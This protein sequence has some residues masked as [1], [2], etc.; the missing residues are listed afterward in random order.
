VLEG[1]LS[2]CCAI[3]TCPSFSRGCSLSVREE[4][5]GDIELRTVPWLLD[6]RSRRSPMIP[7]TFGLFP[8]PILVLSISPSSTWN[9]FMPLTAAFCAARRCGQ[10]TTIVL[11]RSLAEYQVLLKQ[12]KVQIL[13]PAYYDPARNQILCAYDMPHIQDRLRTVHNEHKAKLEQLR[14][15]KQTL[16]KLSRERSRQANSSRSS[17][18]AGGSR[19]LTSRTARTP[20]C[21]PS[22][23]P[24]ALPRSVSCLPGGICLPGERRGRAAL[25]Q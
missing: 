11:P 17:T 2:A 4:D 14:V 21:C 24:H 23:F 12:E 1:R 22:P 19:E 20:S 10:P 25:A 9:R 7:F 5:L 3:A 18:P 6:A 15:M 8:T 13:N 16:R